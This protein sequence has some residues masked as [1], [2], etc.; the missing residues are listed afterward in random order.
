MT[1]HTVPTLEY[2]LSRD[3]AERTCP[4]CDA[5][6][7]TRPGIHAFIG[8]TDDIV[9]SRAGCSSEDES[10]TLCPCSTLFEFAPL[11]AAT[12]AALRAAPA[13]L[14]VAERL[15]L[16]GLDVALPE[17]DRALLQFA[18]IDLQFCDAAG[19]RIRAWEPNL[20]IET[21][22]EAAAELLLSGCGQ[23]V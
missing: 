5:S 8:G 21:C 9:C 17:D 3:T 16:A 1:S 23:L 22:G 19:T 7:T 11:S 14:D 2:R 10:N 6:F 13:T 20:V 4:L 18:A 15:R 12:I